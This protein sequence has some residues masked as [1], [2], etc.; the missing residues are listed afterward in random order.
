MDP[1]SFDTLARRFLARLP[2]RGAL[3]VLAGG[4]TAPL[5]G[6]SP[7]VQAGCKKVGKTCDKNKDCCKN[8]RCG[9]K[10]CKC[11]SGFTECG[12]KCF[13]LNE[14]EKHCGSCNTACATGE[15]CVAGVCAEGGCTANR[16]S[17]AEDALCLSCPD[18]ADAVCYLDNDDQVRCSRFL[19]CFT[20]EDD[21]DCEGFGQN[22]RCIASCPGQCSGTACASD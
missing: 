20:C 10:K 18:R 2:R 3:A 22:A 19:L 12:G 16:D 15:R 9:G 7:P 5:L 4:V 8:A 13:D 11:K 1:Q 14:D 21:S 17:C 6:G